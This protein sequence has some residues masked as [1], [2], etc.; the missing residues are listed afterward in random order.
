MLCKFRARFTMYIWPNVLHFRSIS[1]IGRRVVRRYIGAVFEIFWCVCEFVGLATPAVVMLI[2]HCVF[3]IDTLVM[4]LPLLIELLGGSIVLLH[5]TLNM[6]LAVCGMGE[7][8]MGAISKN[9][10]FWHQ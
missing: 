10:L 5:V 4:S 3:S 8:N 1:Q 2:I 6:C 7:G 9:S